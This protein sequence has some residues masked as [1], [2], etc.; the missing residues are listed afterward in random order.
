[1][2]K[3]NPN[4]PIKLFSKNAIRDIAIEEIKFY[5]KVPKNL[6]E[7][8]L[9]YIAN[10]IPL[11]ADVVF[12]VTITTFDDIGLPIYNSE[13]FMAK[14]KYDYQPFFKTNNQAN[15][16]FSVSQYVLYRVKN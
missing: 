11:E 9:I 6:A 13:K 10:S 2:S 16:N 8:I 5:R 14:I 4:S 1:M 15:I 7:K 12:N 3:D